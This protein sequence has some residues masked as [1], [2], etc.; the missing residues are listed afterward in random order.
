M[1]ALDEL[2]ALEAQTPRPVLNRND[3]E[4]EFSKGLRGNIASMGAQGQAFL[5]SAGRAFGADGFAADRDAAAQ[6]GMQEAQA[7]EQAAANPTWDSVH[8]LRDFGNWMGYRGGQLAP[9]LAGS[10]LAGGIGGLA[11]KSAAGAIAGPA[12]A[13]TPFNTGDIALRQQQEQDPAIQA[14][15][16]MERFGGQL[17]TGAVSSLV[18]NAPGGYLGGKIVGKGIAPAISRH[19]VVSPLEQGAASAGGEALKQVG[20]NPEAPL[21]TDAITAAGVGGAAVGTVLGAG[22][23]GVDA[24]QGVPGRIAQGAKDAVGGARNMASDALKTGQ[25]AVEG[26]EAPQGAKDAWSSVVELADS[27]YKGATESALGKTIVERTA[28]A[29]KLAEDI[30]ADPQV[31]EEWKAK[32]QAGAKDAGDK[33]YQGIVWAADQLRNTKTAVEESG[34]AATAIKHLKGLKDSATNVFENIRNGE[35][36]GDKDALARATPEQAKRMLDDDQR[37]NASKLSD[38]LEGFKD[39]AETPE[40]RANAE[41][42]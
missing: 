16:P 30:I 19:M 31:P 36:G 7:A 3:E 39:K 23:V 4:S 11:A 29:R 26:V 33:A 22:H 40:E 21:N 28:A 14:Q 32:L 1:S 41:R 24:M 25:K 35:F 37:S 12:V 20:A 5:G 18:E 17:A 34:A 6:A 10:V 42:M 15:S 8:G 9:G 13:F 38:W 2:R 27:A